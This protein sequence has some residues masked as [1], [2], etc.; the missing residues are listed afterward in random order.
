MNTLIA[1]NNQTQNG[2]LTQSNINTLVQA[3]II[4]RGTPSEQVRVFA[5][6]C[7]ERGISPFSK[8]IYLVGYGGKYYTIVGINGFRKIAS[9]TGQHAGTDD[10]KFNVD[11]KGNFKTAS[12]LKSEGKNPTS[13]TVTVYRVVSGLRVPYT[14]TAVFSEFA[15]SGKWKTMPFQMIAKVAEA[16]ALRKG[17]SDRLTGLSIPEEKV[18]I[19]DAQK[20]ILTQAEKK[21]VDDIIEKAKSE[22]D[23][24]D[25]K[26]LS[27][28]YKENSS[29]QSNDD[30]LEALTDRKN[31]LLEEIKERLNG[32]KLKGVQADWKRNA[33]YH[34]MQEVKF[35]YDARIAE[36]QKENA[37]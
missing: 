18:A 1:S 30:I 24:K 22:I 10:A 27:D 14:H 36:L 15:G 5:R 17:F 6:V 25:L 34:N 29:L 28:W 31:T 9:E 32:L 19:E 12:E 37:E 7:Q 35:I 21:Q 11:S 2:E 3:G 13:A 26:G 4:P 8:E 33:N 16:F 20:P 23:K